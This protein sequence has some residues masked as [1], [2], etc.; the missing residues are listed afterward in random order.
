MN[1]AN[2]LTIF[3]VILI[4]FFVIFAFVSIPGEVLGMPTSNFIML[5]IFIVAAITDKLD[6]D[7]ARKY[8]MVTNFGKFLDPLADKLLVNTALIILVGTGML[9]AWIAVIIIG[10]EFIITGVRLLAVEDGIVIAAN[11]WGKVKTVT[12]M[13]A[14]ILMLID[15]NPFGA[16]ITTVLTGVPLYLNILSTLM[17]SVATIATVFSLVIYLKDSK[18]VILK[19]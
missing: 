13:I 7:I 14:V 2:K 8:N 17:M 19:K 3:R 10:R 15:T 16:C 12:Q 5:L 4:P 18:E 6:G 1:L 11:I 9:P